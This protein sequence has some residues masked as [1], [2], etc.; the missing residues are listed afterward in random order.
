LPRGWG[1]FYN[2]SPSVPLFQRGKKFPQSSFSKREEISLILFFKRENDILWIPF[3]KKGKLF[4]TISLII[5]RQFPEGLAQRLF[6]RKENLF[7]LDAG[8]RRWSL[9]VRILLR[10]GCIQDCE[11]IHVG[12]ALAAIIAAKAAPTH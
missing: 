7:F 1:D 5:L 11:S 9:A 4:V 10:Y 6:E 3:F 12:A 8:R 2:K